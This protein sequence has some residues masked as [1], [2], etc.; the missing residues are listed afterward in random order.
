MK[1]TGDKEEAEMEFKTKDY[2]TWDEYLKAHPEMEAV[3][4]ARKIQDYEDQAFSLM[5]RLF[6]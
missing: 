5:M 1:F 3:Q 4:G 2:V 6:R